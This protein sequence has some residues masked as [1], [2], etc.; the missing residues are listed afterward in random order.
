M[1]HRSLPQVNFVLA[2]LLRPS[3]VVVVVVCSFSAYA[4][5]SYAVTGP[6]DYRFFPPFLKGVNANANNH[7]GAEN[8]QIARSLAAGKGFA[9]PFG[10]PMGPTAWMP[11]LL[12]LFLAGLLRACN[13]DRFAVMI[14]VI[15]LQ[16]LTLIATGFLVLTLARKA[17]SRTG[18]WLTA[19]VFLAGLVCEFRLC[20]QL[21]HDCWLVL[22]TLNLLVI[23]LCWGHPLRSWRTAV[24]WGLFGGFCA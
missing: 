2:M 15:V 18:P 12:P 6:A 3:T 5:L 11:P 1:S 17:V 22:L 19:A 9:D 14:A 24:V 23:G 20:F 21:T 4:N 13:G 7:L 8:F 16:N 10:V